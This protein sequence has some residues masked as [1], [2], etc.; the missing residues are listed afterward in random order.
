[1]SEIP[2]DVWD[3]DWKTKSDEVENMLGKAEKTL[4]KAQHIYDM[5]VKDTVTPGPPPPPGPGPSPAPSKQQPKID[6]HLQPVVLTEDSNPT[7]FLEWKDHQR[8]R[9]Q[10]ERDPD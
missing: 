7:K 5:A 3:K 9:W 8:S 10:H 6:I 1:M 4:E 2:D